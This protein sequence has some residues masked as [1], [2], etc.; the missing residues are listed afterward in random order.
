MKRYDDVFTLSSGR[1]IYA[2]RYILGI[3]EDEG[4]VVIS[5]GY[6]GGIHDQDTFTVDEKKEL[7]EYAIGLW[8]RWG[9]L[10]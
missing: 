7:A 3:S 2:N 10:P 1:K 5:E 9:N 4:T 8:K 6:D